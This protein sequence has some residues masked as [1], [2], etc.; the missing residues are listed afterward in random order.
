[1]QVMLLI[2]SESLIIGFIGGLAG[3]VAGMICAHI[4]T[5]RSLTIIEGVAFTASPVI[6][7]DLILSAI[8]LS[9]SVGAIGGLLPAL[10]AAKLQP[11][12]ALRY[13]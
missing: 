8:L 3:V 11:V 12:E 10:R 9:L 4:L 1:R 13:E 7:I 6:S 5:K 2:L